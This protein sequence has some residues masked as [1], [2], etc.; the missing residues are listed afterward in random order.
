[1]PKAP[2]VSTWTATLRFQ[3]AAR[4]AAASEDEPDHDPCVTQVQRPEQPVAERASRSPTGHAGGEH[5]RDE[6]RRAS[7]PDR[8]R[9]PEVDREEEQERRHRRALAHAGERD[10]LDDAGA[11]QRVAS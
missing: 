2:A 9:Q 11:A 10:S 3:G 6:Q 1:M 8:G 7:A 4:S 5:D